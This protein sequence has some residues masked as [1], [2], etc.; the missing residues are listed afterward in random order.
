MKFLSNARRPLQL[1]STRAAYSF[2]LLSLCKVS[3][4]LLCAGALHKVSA[5]R[6]GKEAEGRSEFSSC[7]E[8]ITQV[9]ATINYNTHARARAPTDGQLGAVR[10]HQLTPP[11]DE[12]ISRAAADPI[13]KENDFFQRQTRPISA[14][15]FSAT[16]LALTPAQSILKKTR[17]VHNSSRKFN[18][19]WS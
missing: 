4:Y 8:Y 14:V 15:K 19:Y 10:V 6:E 1:F 17:C 13:S 16:P 11:R 9:S 3:L 7:Q 2:S 5:E 12:T 18:R